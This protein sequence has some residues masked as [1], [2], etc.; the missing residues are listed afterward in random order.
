MEEKIYVLNRMGF[1]ICMM[2]NPITQQKTYYIYSSFTP[3]EAIGS[4]IRTF[5]HVI[6]GKDITRFLSERATYLHLRTSDI[7]DNT[8]RTQIAALFDVE[9]QYSS[10]YLWENYLSVKG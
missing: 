1:N 5:K 4:T 9:H 8:I 10:H 6:K 2:L 3:V 7:E